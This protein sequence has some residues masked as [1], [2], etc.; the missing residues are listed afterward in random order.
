MDIK[1]TLEKMLSRKTTA[2][3]T[4]KIMSLAPSTTPPRRLGQ[5]AQG[6]GFAR[7][8]RAQPLEPALGPPRKNSVVANVGTGD[9]NGS[10]SL[11]NNKVKVSSGGN[12]SD[13]KVQAL[14]DDDVS[15]NNNRTV[16]YVLSC[17]NCWNK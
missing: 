9:G 5:D 15:A 11:D 12:L 16:I 14:A 8:S 2:P 17:F 13:N 7:Q 10:D 6:S 4:N 3:D 1:P